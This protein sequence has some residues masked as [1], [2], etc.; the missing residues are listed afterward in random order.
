MACVSRA[1]LEN[2]RLSTVFCRCVR[3]SV[4][5][6]GRVAIIAVVHVNDIFAAQLKSKAAIIITASHMQFFFICTSL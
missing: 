4:A 5:E 2:T 1:K 6:E 3:F